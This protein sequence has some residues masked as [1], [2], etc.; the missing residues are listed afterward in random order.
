MWSAIRPSFLQL[1]ISSIMRIKAIP[2]NPSDALHVGH[3]A[4]PI[5]DLAEAEAED[6]AA[7]A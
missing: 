2:M 5:R 7:A 6:L 3:P 4:D 1:T